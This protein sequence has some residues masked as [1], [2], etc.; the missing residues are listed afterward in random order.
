MTG[1]FNI[2]GYEVAG[3]ELGTGISFPFE[4]SAP[5]AAAIEVPFGGINPDPTHCPGSPDSPTAAPGYL[6][7]Y[8]R[9][10]VNA[11]AG[12]QTDL[13]IA[14]VSSHGTTSNFGAQIWTV[15]KATGHVAVVGSWAVTAP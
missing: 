7:V 8:D 13:C 3:G 9:G 10:A 1:L 2:D 12:C 6:C 14:D 11:Q 4:L 5:P 15:A